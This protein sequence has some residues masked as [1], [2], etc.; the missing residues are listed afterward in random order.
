M[1]GLQVQSLVGAHVGGSRSMFL[2]HIDASLLL[3]PS[4]P[5]SLTPVSMSSDEDKKMNLRR[6]YLHNTQVGAHEIFIAHQGKSNIFLS[7]ENSSVADTSLNQAISQHPQE[8]LRVT[9]ADTLLSAV[10][11]G[12][13][14]RH[15]ALL[16]DR[17][18]WSNQEGTS[19]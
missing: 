5:L 15:V 2:S 12:Q 19:G 10:A 3:S 9:R 11:P 13:D 8:W 18:P 1:P 17:K 4:I 16:P 14:T 6:R 7:V